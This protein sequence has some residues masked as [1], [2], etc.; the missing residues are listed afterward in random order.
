MVHLANTDSGSG[1]EYFARWIAA[2]VSEPPPAKSSLGTVVLVCVV[3]AVVILVV[4]AGVIVKRRRAQSS[5][6]DGLGGLDQPILDDAIDDK[7]DM[8]TSW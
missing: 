1:S 6:G 3:A 5:G 8:R 2:C 4:V 7:S